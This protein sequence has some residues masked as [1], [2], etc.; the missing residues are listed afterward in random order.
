MI[1]LDKYVEGLETGVPYEIDLG[2]GNKFE[3][4]VRKASMRDSKFFKVQ[5]FLIN[6]AQ[7]NQSVTRLKE[8]TATEEPDE[9][10]IASVVDDMKKQVNMETF[11]EDLTI[12]CE[13]VTDELAVGWRGI[14]VTGTDEPR[15]FDRNLLAKLFRHEPMHAIGVF[16]FSLNAANFGSEPEQAEKN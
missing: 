1:D 8:L 16:G 5:E 2:E 3:L 13:Y 15:E 4:M 14:T 7:S 12:L 10:L 6:M 9:A 11:S